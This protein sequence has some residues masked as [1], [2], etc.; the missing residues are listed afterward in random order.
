MILA[1]L[2]IMHASLKKYNLDY[3][4]VPNTQTNPH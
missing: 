1:P 3:D 4:D 2:V